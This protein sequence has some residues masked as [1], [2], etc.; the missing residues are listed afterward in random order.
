MNKI[1]K[2]ATIVVIMVG[3]FL[4]MAVAGF[5]VAMAQGDGI[6][7]PYFGRYRF[8]GMQITSYNLY[9]NSATDAM[10]EGKYDGHGTIACGDLDPNSIVFAPNDLFIGAENFDFTF[11]RWSRLIND[12]FVPEI[13]YIHLVG[14]I[15]V[16]KEN[17][18]RK[19]ALIS[20]DE[21][22]RL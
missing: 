13:G 1:V 11:R 22:I 6:S 5:N 2:L 21:Y 17:G 9:L 19:R 4:G 15:G 20:S 18:Y 14:Y 7:Q 10:F 16:D 3:Y 12:D 8:Q